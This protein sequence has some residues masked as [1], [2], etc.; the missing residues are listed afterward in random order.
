MNE[1]NI[2]DR[3][4]ALWRDLQRLTKGS[5]VQQNQARVRIRMISEIAELE[6][7][8]KVLSRAINIASAYGGRSDIEAQAIVRFSLGTAACDIAR[9]KALVKGAPHE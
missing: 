4:K 2:P 3:W 9:S 8:N 5:K 1:L 6:D 7:R